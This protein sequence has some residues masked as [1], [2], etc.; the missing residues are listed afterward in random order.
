MNCLSAVVLLVAVAAANAGIV[1][2]VDSAAVLSGPSGTVVRSGLAHAPFAYH[3]LHHAYAAPIA[4][5]GIVAGAPLAYAAVPAG[6]GLEGQW[7]PDINEKFYDDGSY[8][9]H[10]Y[11][12]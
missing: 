11:G 5:H 1:A 2:P 6:H 4:H 9:P 8:K 12:F 3:G 7:I 10:I